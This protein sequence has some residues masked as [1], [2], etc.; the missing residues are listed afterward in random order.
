MGLT[1]NE[2]HSINLADAARFTA[3]YRDTKGDDF[4]AGYF[5][6]GAIQ[7]ILDQQGCVGLRIYNAI[8]D[9]NKR[10]LVVVGVTVDNKDISDGELAEFMIGCPPYCDQGSPLFSGT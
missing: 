7:G 3:A 9:N 6:K 1:G 5:G 10:T 2:G 4:L 8:D